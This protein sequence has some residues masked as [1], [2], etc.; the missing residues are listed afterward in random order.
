MIGLKPNVAREDFLSIIDEISGTESVEQLTRVCESRTA[1][2]SIIYHHFSP[3]GGPNFDKLNRFWTSGLKPF[4]SDFLDANYATSDPGMKYVFSTARPCWLS[5]LQDL[6]MF[7]TGRNKLRVHLAMKHIGDSL[8]LPLFGPYG[9]RGYIFITFGKPRSFYDPIFVWQIQGLLQAVH[10]RY[11]MIVEGFRKSVELT[12]R[13]GE[14]LELITFGKTNPEIGIILGI[15][16][17]TVSGH[18][19]RIFLKFDA[20]DRVTVALQARRFNL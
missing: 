2:E 3:D 8:L 12:K 1:Y 5:D 4:V 16:A 11:C 19:K 17:S 13:E 9:R 7:S 14:V 6:E 18:V 15:S 10:I 20:K